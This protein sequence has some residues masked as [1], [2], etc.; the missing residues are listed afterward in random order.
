[1]NRNGLI[2]H[3]N[4]WIVR[5]GTQEK[6]ANKCKI[7]TTA[8]SLWMSGKYGADTAK[9]ENKIT[10]ALNYKASD[11]VFV[12]E[13]KNYKT[14]EFFFNQCREFHLWIGFDSKAGSGKTGGFEHLY[15]KDLSGSVIFI[16]AENWSEKQFLTKLYEKLSCTL[17]LN[18]HQ[19]NAK[20]FDM[21]V[22]L[23]KQ[24]D[25]PVLIVDEY[26]KLKR[27]AKKRLITL[28]NRTEDHLG[29]IVSG[30]EVKKEIHDGVRRQIGWYDETD[31]RLGRTY[32]EL[33]GLVKKDV[34]QLCEANG[35]TDD[36]KK[37]KVWSE[38]E[39][40]IKPVKV[41]K[42]N[43]VVECNVLH[44]EDLRRLKR[45]IIR[46]KISEKVNY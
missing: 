35:V 6:V 42:G 32:I 30:S 31:S 36:E 8:L 10:Q 9:L 13:I 43:G 28:Y 16:Q 12:E 19:S 20:I 38:V 39:K 4:D 21:I 24:L 34:F 11:W 29:C 45:L 14:A 40:V 22:V 46:E 2:K 23:I 15:N 37:E 27:A 18:D 1:M 44:C 17:L 3:V 41:K 26:T 33:P 25:C 5:L 7:S